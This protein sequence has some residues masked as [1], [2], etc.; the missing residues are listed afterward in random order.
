MTIRHL[1]HVN[2]M[3]H[4]L[5]YLRIAFSATCLIACVLLIALWM[6]SYWWMDRIEGMTLQGAKVTQIFKCS[7]LRG[8]ITVVAV[9]TLR[10]IWSANLWRQRP[11]PA[12]RCEGEPYGVLG[13]YSDEIHRSV[14]HWFPFTVVAI[15]SVAPWIRWRFS[16]RTLLIATTLVGVILGFVVWLSR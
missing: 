14:P 5:R 2:R 6:R 8:Q 15:L 12:E 11:F 9:P 4:S 16:L 7:S 1:C 13:F 10:S 3:R